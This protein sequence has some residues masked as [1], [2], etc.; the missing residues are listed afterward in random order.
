MLSSP[1]EAKETAWD[2]EKARVISDGSPLLGPRR[3]PPEQ[4][5]RGPLPG[6]GRAVRARITNYIGRVK[7]IERGV[8]GAKLFFRYKGRAQALRR[9]PKGPINPEA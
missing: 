8:N 3:F 1:T 5:P 9:T 2:K 6:C 4:L 7:C